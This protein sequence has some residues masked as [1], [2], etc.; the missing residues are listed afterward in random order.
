[1]LNSMYYDNF[2]NEYTTEKDPFAP[3]ER[4]LPTYRGDGNY[5][6]KWKVRNPNN[7]AAVNLYLD[8]AYS[9]LDIEYHMVNKRRYSLAEENHVELVRMVRRTI[10]ADKFDEYVERFGLEK[11]N[12]NEVY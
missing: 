6:E 5:V 1:M 12:D 4:Y 3:P 2:A 11:E 8:V 7:I 10:P 9:P